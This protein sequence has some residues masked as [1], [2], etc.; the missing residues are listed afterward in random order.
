V[1][2]TIATLLVIGIAAFAWLPAPKAV[3]VRS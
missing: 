3:I 1:L 2:A